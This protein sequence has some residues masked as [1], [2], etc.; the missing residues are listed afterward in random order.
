MID[1]ENIERNS[2]EEIESQGVCVSIY[3]YIY[4]Y[5]THARIIEIIHIFINLVIYCSY[6]NLLCTIFSNMYRWNQCRWWDVR[7]CWQSHIWR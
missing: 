1:G 3:I 4:I 5:W 7:K 2:S 6:V